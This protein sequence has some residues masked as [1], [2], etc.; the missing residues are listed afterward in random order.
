M[1]KLV[2]DTNTLI[3]A[4]FWDGNEYKLFKKIEERKAVIFITYE[5]L[6]EVEKVLRRPKF[7]KVLNLTKQRIDQII[8]KIISVSHVIIGSKLKINVCR[9]PEDN[10]FLE[11]AELAKADYIVSGDEDLLSMKQY[12]NI[13]IIKSSDILKL[14]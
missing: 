11:C 8:Q 1:L 5:I 12:K 13:K 6:E 4:F 14:I 10:K 7:L 2:L 9:D 3:S